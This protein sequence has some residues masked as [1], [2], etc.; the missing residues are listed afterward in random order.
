[1]YV[2]K[3][4]IGTGRTGTGFSDRRRKCLQENVYPRPHRLAGTRALLHL[5]PLQPRW[6]ARPVEPGLREH[7]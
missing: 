7:S 5:R 6:P 3:G 1:M 2:Q 4:H